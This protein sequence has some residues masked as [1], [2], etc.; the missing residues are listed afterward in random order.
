MYGDST[1]N[2]LEPWNWLLPAFGSYPFSLSPVSVFKFLFPFL[3]YFFL[4]PFY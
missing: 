3:F 2:V 1:G 4:F